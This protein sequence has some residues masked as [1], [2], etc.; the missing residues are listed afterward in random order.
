M[1]ALGYCLVQQVGTKAVDSR[2]LIA[3]NHQAGHPGG[4]IVIG[5]FG[6]LE[7]INVLAFIECSQ[8]IGADVASGVAAGEEGFTCVGVHSVVD[9]AVLADDQLFCRHCIAADEVVVL[10]VH[11]VVILMD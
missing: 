6:I 3:D 7:G 8:G 11:C 2:S 4:T 9:G 1:L 5:D 10:C